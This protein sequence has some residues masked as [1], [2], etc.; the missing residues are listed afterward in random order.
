MRKEISVRRKRFCA[1][2]LALMLI[3]SSVMP[4][5]VEAEN[6][7]TDSI[8]NDN[9]LVAGDIIIPDESNPVWTIR[10]LDW[11]GN[12]ELGAWEATAEA[13]H[14]VMEYIGKEMD[15]RAFG[16]WKVSEV[17]TSGD[18]SS[19][20]L[21]A[22][23][24][25]MLYNEDLDILYIYTLYPEGDTVDLGTY[26]PVGF[27]EPE[28]GCWRVYSEEA[29]TGF[30]GTL[31]YE[32]RV[33]DNPMSSVTVDNA[34]GVYQRELEHMTI[35]AVPSHLITV[36]TEV[37]SASYNIIGE[38][39][40][41]YN[42][43]IFAPGAIKT[44]VDE[45]GR[46]YI[47][48]VI[49]E[50]GK[51]SDTSR[52]YII[53][54]DNM[55]I[56]NRSSTPVTIQGSATLWV[57]WY[58]SYGNTEQGIINTSYE[59]GSVNK[60]S[61]LAKAG[62]KITI[63]PGNGY[64]VSGLTLKK[65]SSDYS[66][67]DWQEEHIEHKP[68]GTKVITVPD[69]SAN[70]FVNAG[71]MT[72]LDIGNVSGDESDSYSQ[73]VKFDKTPLNI[74]G[75]DWYKES[76]KISAITEEK[77]TVADGIGTMLNYQIYEASAGSDFLEEITVSEEGKNVTKTYFLL[78]KSLT[79]EDWD[80]DGAVD[81]IYTSERY[82]EIIQ[83]NY[84]YTMDL[85]SPEIDNVTMTGA[86]GTD[87]LLTGDWKSIEDTEI[88]TTT[89]TNEST[90]T[91][92]V[93]ADAGN[94]L[95][96]TGYQ[97]RVVGDKNTDFEVENTR[98]LTGNGIYEL[99]ISVQDEFDEMT[100]E[101]SPEKH[102]VGAVGMDTEIP[103][104]YYTDDKNTNENIQLKSNYEYEGKLYLIGEDALSGVLEINAYESEDGVLTK[105]NSVLTAED[106]NGT[107]YSISPA[108]ED[109]VYC[110]EI[111]DIAGNRELY[112]N[113]TVKAGKDS[114]T[115]TPDESEP[116]KPEEDNTEEKEPTTPD[117]GETSTEEKEPAT[118]DEE[119]T[120][121]EE[122]E[123]ATP[124]EGETSTEEKEP[125]TPDEGETSTEE[126]EPTIPDEGETSTEEKEPITPDEEES[127]TPEE[128]DFILQGGIKAIKAGIPYTLGSGTWKVTGDRTS[129][130]GGI[131]FYVAADGVYE[132]TLQ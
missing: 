29:M 86:D 92:R 93:N 87:V 84:T 130:A 9:L 40:M 3:C 113:V 1:F 124:D 116:S 74:D 107:M 67:L 12:N 128:D 68:D 59:E 94:G 108:A 99:Y 62:S 49:I 17:F 121:T 78:D 33:L 109:K 100:A 50:G 122:K 10:Y 56:Y 76:F 120:S 88:K 44:Y 38:N 2:V 71:K 132:F 21:Q 34:F 125:A 97:I 6:Y 25:D 95:P 30:T 77:F 5:R 39:L 112:E 63:K 123:P 24:T 114:G 36:D 19:I 15:I 11:S 82:G 115:T 129:Y 37:F 101:R 55:D 31:T 66:D 80:G 60:D 65:N 28:A 52:E 14:E 90:V 42:T 70:L 41:N 46:E 53:Y 73:Y 131:T 47:T 7:I 18:M 58:E 8:T 35:Y 51:D 43:I 48:N 61:Y 27:T 83:L 89:W 79:G 22:E 23:R 106:K 69:I 81:S 85:K 104:I 20:T 96:I 13:P 32:G 91:I 118:P 54:A 72:V 57:D 111:M 110:I 119:E 117:E 103:M 64:T 102:W 26:L 16:G 75:E 98:I 4:A 45:S 127:I 105:N 126:K